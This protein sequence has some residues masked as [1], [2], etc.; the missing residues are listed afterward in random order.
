[1]S[2]DTRAP[3]TRPYWLADQPDEVPADLFF[4]R[5]L[6]SLYRPVLSGET[7]PY[8]RTPWDINP[9]DDR[10]PQEIIK[11]MGLHDRSIPWLGHVREY[12]NA[13][14]TPALCVS[15]GTHRILPDAPSEL[16]PDSAPMPYMVRRLRYIPRIKRRD[17]RRWA[18]DAWSLC[19][20]VSLEELY[21][22][23]TGISGAYE[24]KPVF[25]GGEYGL[26]RKEGDG[27]QK[28]T[29]MP[30]VR[31]LDYMNAMSEFPSMEAPMYDRSTLRGV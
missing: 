11:G 18:P 2:I 21:S 14:A 13:P 6:V 24:I 19:F 7:N 9:T 17:N 22:R 12:P 3:T 1:M 5:F 30:Q 23:A 29:P 4:A 16:F 25:A 10:Y 28:F 26:L 8:G 27:T 31:A 20:A 15:R